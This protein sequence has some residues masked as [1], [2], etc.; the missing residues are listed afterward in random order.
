M[1]AFNSD[2][3]AYKCSVSR[4][5]ADETLEFSPAEVDKATHLIGIGLSMKSM[6]VLPDHITGTPFVLRF[7]EDDFL[8]LERTDTKSTI[9]F[10]WGEGD[11]LILALQAALAKAKDER[12]LVKGPRGT[13]AVTVAETPFN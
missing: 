12:T 5:D 13:G 11:E 4:P 10:R 8:R 2:A 1:G 7:F 9:K 6:A 3:D